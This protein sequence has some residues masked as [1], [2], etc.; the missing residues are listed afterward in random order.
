MLILSSVDGNKNITALLRNLSK[1]Y[2]VPLSTLKLNAQI[3]KKQ[4][5]LE[6]N[7]TVD[8]TELG[9]LILKLIGDEHEK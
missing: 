5:L 6:W 4:G 3:L 2:N 9:I 7:G 1:Y 8:L